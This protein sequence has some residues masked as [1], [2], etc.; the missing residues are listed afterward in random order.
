[1][2]GNLIAL[3]AFLALFS[4]SNV[5]AQEC[6]SCTLVVGWIE[7]WVDNNETETT[8]LGWIEQICNAFPG[9]S[10][11][12]DQIADQGLTQI[13]AWINQDESPDTICQ[14]L[15][16]C[17]SL[18]KSQSAKPANLFNLK[19]IKKMNALPKITIP[20]FPKAKSPKQDVECSGCEEAIG[21]IET[22]LDNTSNQDEVITAVE[23]VC[24]YMPDWESTC[25]N[26]VTVG[27]PTVI[28]W[29]EEYENSTLVCGQLG[30]CS[31]LMKK[32]VTLQDDCT[33]CQQIVSMIETY[34]E[35]NTAEQTIV[36]YLDIAC[37]LVPAWSSQCDSV[38]AS[39]VPQIL[40]WI[41][42]NET[43]QEICAQLDVC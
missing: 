28:N 38:I 25:D 4:L 29:I 27:V 35:S 24:S 36:S 10:A 9:Y 19:D 20:G 11:V 37:A 39:E 17:T 22:W 43:P 6:D 18:H 5:H 16:L 13:I 21:V 26:I 8:I 40:Q 34:A 42:A 3:F 23:I 41:E 12:C 30:M 33:V 2:K 1:M 32:P 15:G 31:A 14:Q 7:N